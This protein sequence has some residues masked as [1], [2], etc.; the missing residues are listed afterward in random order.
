MQYAWIDGR[1][2]PP[3]AKKERTTCR[4]CGGD[5]T[6]VMPVENVPHWRHKSGD[7]DP[8]SEPEG[9][10]HLAWKEFFDLS[11][12]EVALRDPVAG[13]LHRADVLFGQGT[14]KA[15]VL[16]LQHSSI[17]EEER[18]ARE[19]FYRREHRMFWLVHIHS[20]TTF[21]AHRFGMSLDFRSRPVEIDG[22]QFGIMR[23]VGPSKQFIEKWK[24]AKA[25]VFFNAGG[26]IYYL[27]GPSIAARLG[28][29]LGRGEFALTHLSVDDFLKAVRSE[30]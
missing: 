1:K 22:R 10:W 28:T 20:D 23:W 14:P 11:S 13:E 19:A 4:D 12:R 16:E 2:R 21:L 24:R 5:L 15:T 9:E 18:D 8:W 30:D 7:C 25:H 29:T 6:A 3:I 26:S 17:S 27:A